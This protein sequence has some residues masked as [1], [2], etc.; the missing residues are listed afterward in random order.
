MSS[1]TEWMIEVLCRLCFSFPSL[2]YCPK[3]SSYH[4][5]EVCEKEMEGVVEMLLPS[6]FERMMESSDLLIPTSPFSVLA[7]LRLVWAHEKEEDTLTRWRTDSP[8][9]RSLRNQTTAAQS[10]S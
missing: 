3:F 6:Y 10:T 2:F 1:K 7:S 5:K 8:R 4:K 9:G